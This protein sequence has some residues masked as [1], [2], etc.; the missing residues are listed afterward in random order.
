MDGG[1]QRRFTDQEASPIRILSDGEYGYHEV[2][3]QGDRDLV[4]IHD[5]AA[6]PRT[7]YGYRWLRMGEPAARE[8]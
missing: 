7:A 8:R 3:M 4:T 6:R 1:T 2:N 5:P